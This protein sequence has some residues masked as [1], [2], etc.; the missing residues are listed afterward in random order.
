MSPHTEHGTPETPAG[1]FEERLLSRILADYDELTSAPVRPRRS[2][3]RQHRARIGI[4]VPVLAAVVIAA[5]VIASSHGSG[6]HA[7]AIPAVRAHNTAYIVRRVRANLADLTVAGEGRVLER[8]STRGAS[9]AGD[10]VIDNVDWAYIDPRTKVAYQRSVDRSATG[11]TL[12]INKLVTTPVGNVLHTQVTFLDPH[13][14]AYTIVTN[15]SPSGTV[16]AARSETELGIKSTAHQID[17]ALRSN[18]VAQHGTATIDRQTTIKLSVPPP[19]SLVKS[20]LSA[21]TM[22]TLYVNARSYQPVQEVDVVP[23]E[24]NSSGGTSI[25]RWLPATRKTIKLAKVRIP[26]DY[27]RITG[28]LTNFW[29][30]AKPLFFIGY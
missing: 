12:S 8:S 23:P 22:I 10:P 17:Q 2:A 7:G 20:R 1:G 19:A 15:A 30:N 21:Q 3:L 25:S 27:R 6:R 24:H 14:H 16:T 11:S 18:R 5:V 28:P 29:T 9:S 26:A 13:R 4:V